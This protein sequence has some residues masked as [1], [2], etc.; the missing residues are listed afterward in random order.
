M[1]LE[2]PSY[3][4]E[5]K[6]GRAETFYRWSGPRRPHAPAPAKPRR[7]R[8]QPRCNILGPTALGFPHRDDMSR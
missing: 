3:P 2:L 7:A 5:G 1:P 8:G 6:L 4:E